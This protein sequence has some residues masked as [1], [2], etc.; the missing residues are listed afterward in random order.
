MRSEKVT[1]L[2]DVPEWGQNKQAVDQMLHYV[3]EEMGRSS[4]SLD[5][6]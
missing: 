5:L 6:Y 1:S 3:A 4:W 2:C